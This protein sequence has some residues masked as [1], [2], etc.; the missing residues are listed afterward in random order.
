M[1]DEV[2]FTNSSGVERLAEEEEWNISIFITTYVSTLFL[3][4]YYTLNNVFFS[5]KNIIIYLYVCRN[6]ETLN[7]S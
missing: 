3:Y 1:L 6:G 2:G 7:W 5:F 4:F